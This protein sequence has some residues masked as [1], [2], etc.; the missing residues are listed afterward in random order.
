M[1]KIISLILAVLTLCTLV[2]F[3]A[4]AADTFTEGAYT[5]TV[6]TGNDGRKY[7][8]L[9]DADGT[10]LSGTINVPE[11]LG[12]Y[13]VEKIG[14]PGF[15]KNLDIKVVI[16]PGSVW[17]IEAGAFRGCTSLTRVTIKSDSKKLYVRRGA[18]SGCDKLEV[19]HYY[20]RNVSYHSWSDTSSYS[21]LHSVKHTDRVEPECAILQK[22]DGREAGW[23]CMMCDKY[24]EGGATIPAKHI[25]EKD[26]NGYCDRCN[27][28]LCA[29]K[30]HKDLD[31]IA[32]F[33]WKIE[34]FFWKLFKIYPECICGAAH[35]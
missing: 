7:A 1:K 13:T 25:D 15:S 30:C 12:G 33:F 23:Y 28:L 35:Y 20:I 6:Q 26:N 3:P 4:D 34:L 8:V 31:G 5:Y 16:I 14:Y 32:E 19:I 10:K 2:V 9:K 17:D 22:E 11:T 21:K 29:H 27:L 24:L 18:F